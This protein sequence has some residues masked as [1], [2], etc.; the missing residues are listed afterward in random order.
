MDNAVPFLRWG[1]CTQ[2]CQ[3]SG[4]GASSSPLVT[5][6][7]PAYPRPPCPLTAATNRYL[8]PLQ[9]AI[10][11]LCN[12]WLSILCRVSGILPPKASSLCYNCFKCFIFD[13]NSVPLPN[14]VRIMAEFR[15]KIFFSVNNWKIR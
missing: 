5:P 12:S 9:D 10:L 7:G 6:C 13:P 2:E 14:D 1:S 11:K 3:R 8:S 4:S 15:R